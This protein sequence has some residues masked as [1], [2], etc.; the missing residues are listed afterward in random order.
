MLIEAA[1]LPS[2][3]SS[4]LKWRKSNT[5]F[6]IVS[7]RSYLIR[8]YYGSR[9]VNNYGSDSGRTGLVTA[10]S[11]TSLVCLSMHF[12]LFI[13]WTGTCLIFIA[14]FKRLFMGDLQYFIV[15]PPWMCTNAFFLIP[16]AQ[17]RDPQGA[18]AG[19]RT[20]DLTYQ[21]A[22]RRTN[23]WAMPHPHWATPHPNWAT[24][25]P[26]WATPHPHWTTPHPHW[27][28]FTPIELPYASPPLSHSSQYLLLCTGLGTTWGCL[29]VA[30]SWLTVSCRLI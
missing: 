13:I 10:K 30:R 20:Q 7:A 29:L 17:Q 25:H 3:L 2:S 11:Y 26:N 28:R 1:L 16:F 14:F 9:T 22:G 18:Q 6:C 5:Q 27:A 15:T 8:F 4:H 12:K 24:L 21:M 19:N 23:H